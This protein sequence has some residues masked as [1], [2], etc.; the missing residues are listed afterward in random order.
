MQSFY[1]ALWGVTLVVALGA[2]LWGCAK[3]PPAGGAEP[4]VGQPTLQGQA[5]AEEQAFA[6]VM[7]QQSFPLDAAQLGYTLQVPAGEEYSVVLAPK[8]ERKGDGGWEDVACTGGFCGTPDQLKES[9]QGVLE[10]AWYPE[11]TAGTY[12]LSFQ[13]W[14]GLETDFDKAQPVS[15]TFELTA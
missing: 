9:H 10:T 14:P 15:A 2:G 4:P 12:R 3:Q 8:L 6:L 5:G 13:A 1:K 11:L 7:E